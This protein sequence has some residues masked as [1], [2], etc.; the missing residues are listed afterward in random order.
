MSKKKRMNDLVLVAIHANGLANYAL[1]RLVKMHKMT[2]LEILEIAH[3]AH[4]SLA[5]MVINRELPNV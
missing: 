1:D 2:E 5:Q 4:V 3:K